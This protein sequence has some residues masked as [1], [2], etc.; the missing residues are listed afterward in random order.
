MISFKPFWDTLS[1]KEVST[2][3]LIHQYGISSSTVN[4]LRHDQPISTVTL[5]DLCTFLHCDV[6][7]IL[8]FVPD[9]PQN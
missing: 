1:S 6:N 2:Y 4:R 3:V 5:N 9:E 7:D 8:I